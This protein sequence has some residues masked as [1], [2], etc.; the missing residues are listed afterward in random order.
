MG[1][2]LTAVPESSSSSATDTRTNR[3]NGQSCAA[4][5]I[6]GHIGCLLDANPGPHN[7]LERVDNIFMGIVW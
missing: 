5:L 2:G 3:A 1:G 4:R 7:N 6:Y